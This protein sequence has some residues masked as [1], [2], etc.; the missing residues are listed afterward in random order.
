[1]KLLAALLLSCG[2]VSATAANTTATEPAIQVLPENFRP[3]QVF[4]NNNLARIIN[5]EKSYVRE[6][7]NVVVENV[8]K[9]PQSEYYVAFPT[10]TIN[11]VGGLEGWPK[12]SE[13]KKKFTVT[14]TRQ[15]PS[16]SHQYFIIHLHQPLE[17][18]AKL[19]LTLS[20]HLQSAL[21]PVP[22]AIEQDGKQYLSYTFP[23]FVPSAYTSNKQKTTVKFRGT[24]VPDYTRPTTLESE[25]DPKREG[26][27]FTYGPYDMEVKPGTSSPIT[28]R[29]EYT[30]PVVTCTRLERD[31]EISHW[32]GNMA[33]EDR[34]W[35]RNDAAKL[36]KQFSRVEWTKKQFHNAQSV[37]LS[38]IRVPLAPGSVNPYFIDD[39]G[40]VSTSRFLPATETRL[41]LLDLRPRYPI[42]GDWKYSFKIGWNNP[43]SSVLRK[44]K[45]GS[46]ESYVLKV[47]FIDGPKIPE[48]VQYQDLEIRIILPEGAENVKYEIVDGLG[49]PNH[50]RS[51][52]SFY[53]TFLDTKGRTVLNLSTTKVGDEAKDGFI[54]VTY[55]YPFL[56]AFRKPLSIFGAILA[57]F[58][59][60][61]VLGNIDVSIKR[62]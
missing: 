9:R 29:Y 27:T 60:A 28:V 39:I 20:Y 62:R 24:D 57:V 38:L 18:A 41:G 5:L 12:D 61:W 36:T 35:F 37:A 21:T 22:A 3:P 58:T 48:G 43:L 47:P 44:Q 6:S 53:K 23:Q 14:S 51:E 11:K 42:F 25:E 56:A 50:I 19:T 8:D 33:T 4:R 31:I 2:L 46:G 52:I 32:G 59:A 15:I 1:M 17:P 55:D 13:E 40:N 54:I 45:T 30:R 10:D 26:S 16:S 34:F 7:I 49:I